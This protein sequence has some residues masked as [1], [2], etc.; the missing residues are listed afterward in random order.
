MYR[1]FFLFFPLVFLI[2]I[3]DILFPPFLVLH[4]SN[5]CTPRPTTQ[6]LHQF[7]SGYTRTTHM[8]KCTQT[9]TSLCW[10]TSN[11]SSQ[12][13]IHNHHVKQVSPPCKC[14]V[15]WRVYYV[16]WEVVSRPF[17]S[18]L[19]TK[20]KEWQHP[21]SL[22]EQGHP[23]WGNLLIP[24][25]CEPSSERGGNRAKKGFTVGGCCI[26]MLLL[27]CGSLLH[28]QQQHGYCSLRSG[29]F[30]QARHNVHVVD[31]YHGDVREKDVEGG[32][33][34][35]RGGW[36]LLLLPL[37]VAQEFVN[38]GLLASCVVIVMRAVACSRMDRYIW[39]L[40]SCWVRIKWKRKE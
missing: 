18:K 39:R 7:L 24:M 35:T 30:F 15:N 10:C 31:T 26:V 3:F 40:V 29:T 6:P 21:I 2:S 8:L 38:R 9:N 33:G 23:R 28:H 12:Q 32:G 27:C 25:W 34:E 16:C 13:Y 19:I 4:M 20:G 36:L 17:S 11:M 37:I 1:I 14:T 22:C 5:M